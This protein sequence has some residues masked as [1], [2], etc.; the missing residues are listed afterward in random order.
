[1]KT[2][3]N[4]PL[5]KETKALLLSVLKQGYFTDENISLLGTKINLNSFPTEINFILDKR[6]REEWQADNQ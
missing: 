6:T 4:K 1:M 2:K 5:D 3:K